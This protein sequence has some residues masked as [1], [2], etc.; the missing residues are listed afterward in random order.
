MGL[1]Y[2]KRYISLA[3]IEKQYNSLLN[4]GQES[5]EGIFTPSYKEFIIAGCPAQG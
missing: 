3:E 5:L 2:T 4:E 1:V